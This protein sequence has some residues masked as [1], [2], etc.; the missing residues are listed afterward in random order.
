MYMDGPL[1]SGGEEVAQRPVAGM[2]GWRREMGAG[3]R[4]L[5][6]V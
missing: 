3:G 5:V 4:W 1:E 2:M 6:M